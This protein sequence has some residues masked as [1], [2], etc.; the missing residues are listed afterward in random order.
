MRSSCKLRVLAV[1]LFAAG[2]ALI[3]STFA[4]AAP[5]PA[6]AGAKAKQVWQLLDY[7]AVD[8][9]G[10]V[11]QGV[12]LKESEYE[13]MQEFAAAAQR[14]LGE[15]PHGDA[16]DRLQRQAAQLQ[17][18]VAAK[19]DPAIVANQAHQLAAE[20]LKAYPFPI[21]PGVAPD[22][23]RG[24]SLFQSQC[25]ACHGAQGHGD[26]PLAATLEPKPTALSEPGRA[27]ERSLFALHQIISNGVN[28]TAMASFASLPEQDRWALAFFVGTLPYSQADK[29]AGAKLWQSNATLRQAV[30]NLDTLTQTSEHALA[31]RS[32]GA[33]AKALTAYLRGNPQALSAVTAAG[34]G[35]AKAKLQESLAAVERGDR[36]T[37]T[38]LALSAYLDGFEPVEPALAARDRALFEKIE[39]GMVAYRTSLAGASLDALRSSEQKLQDL[40]DEADAALAP[41][42]NDAAAAFVGALTI[43]LREGLEA[44]LVVVAMVAFLKKAERPDVLVYVHA[45]WVLALA[46]GGVTWAV[47]T[48]L[49][50][51]SGASRELTEGFSSLFAAVVLLGVGMWMHQKSVA[52]RWQVYLREKLSAALNKRAAWF[53]FSLAFIAVYRE[54]FETVL[55]YAALWTEGNG[56]P[57]LAGLGSG[58]ALLGILAVV[59]VR[60]ST[61]LPISQFFAASSLLVAV[62]AVVL[63]GKG[64][65]GL[66]EAGLLANSPIAIPRID[67]LGIYPSWQT[68]LAQGA[69][70]LTVVGAFLFN[71][72]SEPTTAKNA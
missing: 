42:A 13:E 66:Q 4:L 27:R 7:V 45:G 1:R 62:L 58:A 70:L 71:V 11:S 34:T 28:G 38:Q 6:D 33:S 35:I 61:R 25:V 2:A 48:Y 69:V 12:V 8:Y 43:L 60:T 26:G 3:M 51:V 17:S 22:L 16:S 57:L 54:V 32:D 72:R 39:A 9:R 50:G 64:I 19:A 67:M 40:L 65:A 21:A 36:A 5:Q 49:V 52:G 44:L 37:A 20:V 55:F 31:E 53:L 10:A 15:L 63:A 41:S 18:S 14:Q 23:A 30:P 29:L 68:L 59:L 46:A 47:A 24:A 56:W